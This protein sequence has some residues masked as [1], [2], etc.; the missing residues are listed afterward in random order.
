MFVIR[1]E[2]EGWKTAFR[3]FHKRKGVKCYLEAMEAKPS[4]INEDFYFSASGTTFEVEK[5]KFED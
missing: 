4:K 2:E 5:I 1:I 3:F